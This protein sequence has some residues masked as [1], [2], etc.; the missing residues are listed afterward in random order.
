MKSRRARAASGTS[1]FVTPS[2]WLRQRLQRA[3]HQE[4]IAL[5]DFIHQS[6]NSREYSLISEEVKYMKA[7]GWIFTGISLLVMLST[8]ASIAESGDESTIAQ[9]SVVTTSD[10]GDGKGAS[11]ISFNRADLR[12]PHILRVY[13]MLDNELVPMERVDV[14]MNGK[15]VKTIANGSL[16]IDLAPM[17]KAGRYDVK[18]SGKSE[19]VDTAISLYFVGKNVNINQQSSGTGK[20][21]RQLIINVR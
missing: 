16:E 2:E 21:D 19:R 1:R 7:L 3:F 5:T 8:C 15:V 14:Q 20:I 6:S 18:I 17:M 11:S 13:G 9:T 4:G 10:D 12:K